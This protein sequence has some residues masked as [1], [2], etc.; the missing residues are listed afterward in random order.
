MQQRHSAFKNVAFH[1]FP[2]L[3]SSKMPEFYN[4]ANAYLV[5]ARVEGGPVP[6]LEAMS[7]G[8]PVVTTP[9]G[10]ALDFV[11]DVHNGLTVPIDNVGATVDAI[12]RIHR[13]RGLASRLGAAGRETILEN[14]QWKNTVLKVDQLYSAPRSGRSSTAEHAT[15]PF[16]C[17]QLSSELIANDTARWEHRMKTETERYRKAKK[18]AALPKR[19]SSRAGAVSA[20]LLPVGRETPFSRL[21]KNPRGFRR[22]LRFLRRLRRRVATFR[23][24]AL[25]ARQLNLGIRLGSSSGYAMNTAADYSRDSLVQVKGVSK[26]FCRDL[27]KSL[28]YGVRDIAAELNPFQSRNEESGDKQIEAGKS[29]SPIYQALRAGE[30]WAVKDVSFELRRGE[31]LGLIGRNGAGK[32]TLLKMLNGLIKPDHGR[33]EMH[34]RA[35]ALIALGAGFNP[36]LTG[37]ENIYVNGAGP[38]LTKRE[39]DEKVDEIIDFAE[40]KE[41][42]DSPVQSYSS[43]MQVR[44]GFAVATAL[45]PDILLLDEVLAVGDAAFRGKCFQRVWR[46]FERGRGHLCEPQRGSGESHL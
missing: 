34:G 4:A 28:W 39:I 44:L 24:L 7:C 10:T 12:E 17:A 14:L 42:I 36:I 19:L 16:P 21:L 1:Y 25:C 22:R 32:T 38:G 43:G 35:G 13:D 31:C 45:R 5:T 41:F 20:E 23:Y 15:G 30:F 33:I 18:L 2:F 26:K 6:L 8:V 29:I 3:P 9:V 37:R 27:K 46:D 40:I 11:R